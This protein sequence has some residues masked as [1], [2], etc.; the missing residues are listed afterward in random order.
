MRY[1]I[2]ALTLT[3]VLLA[4]PAALAASAASAACPAAEEP[5][6]NPVT[7]ATPAVID[8][9]PQSSQCPGGF[10]ILKLFP[11]GTPEQACVDYCTTSGGTVVEY[12]QSNALYWVCSCCV[13]S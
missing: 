7:L 6:E 4:A 11:S 10:P 12:D 3:L 9:A 13:T 5:A 2:P 8:A 1:S